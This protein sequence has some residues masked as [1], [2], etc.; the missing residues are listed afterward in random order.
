M[1]YPVKIYQ[2]DGLPYYMVALYIISSGIYLL[3]WASDSPFSTTDPGVA[4]G[5][6]RHLA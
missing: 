4:I 5:Q 1:L 6:G 2:H 3:K